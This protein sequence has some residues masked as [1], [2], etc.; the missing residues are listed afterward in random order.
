M[1]GRPKKK[2]N[3]EQG[4]VDGTGRKLR[5]TRLYIKYSKCKKMVIISLLASIH[6]LNLNRKHNQL[7]LK[8][9]ELKLNLRHNQLSLRLRELKLNLRHNQLSLNPRYNQ[10]RLK[11]TQRIKKMVT[12]LQS[13]S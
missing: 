2:R 6:Q 3:L 13:R 7:S 4:E 1:L 9:I 5:R 11:L 8:L 10:L 12:G